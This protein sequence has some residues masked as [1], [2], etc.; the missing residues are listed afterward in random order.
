M[1]PNIR[2]SWKIVADGKDIT[3]TLAGRIVSIRVTD[4]SGTK[5]DECE[6]VIDDTITN[7]RITYPATGAELEIWIGYDNDVALMGKFYVDE[8]TASGPPD[9]L[10]VTA[11]AMPQG[12]GLGKV[13]KTGMDTYKSRPWE[14]GTTLGAMVKRIAADHGLKPAIGAELSAIALPHVDQVDESDINLLTRVCKTYGAVPK[15]ADGQL[16]VVKIADGKTTSGKDI[17]PILLKPSDVTTWSATLAKRGAAGSVVAVWR[18]KGAAEDV[19]VTAGEGEPVKR[20]RN[21]YPNSDTAGN[22][23]KSELESSR[24]SK[25][26]LSISMPGL[27]FILAEAQLTIANFREGVDGDWLIR[28]VEHMID[29]KDYHCSIEAEIPRAGALSL[30]ADEAADLEE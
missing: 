24:R 21:P 28:S 10:T 30:D 29:A 1:P 13:D 14:D 20:L 25:Q 11:R 8:I 16:V 12:G 5:S 22:A 17:P 3:A 23:A 18:D 4:D 27:N 7:P 15:P 6:I 2:P 26:K 19:E 9:R